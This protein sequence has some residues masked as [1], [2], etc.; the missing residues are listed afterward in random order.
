[1]SASFGAVPL[2]ERTPRLLFDEQL[3]PQ[4]VRQLA[5][6]FPDSA[7]VYDL[8]LGG[9]RDSAV[10]DAALQNGFVLITKDEDFQS[11][12]V[13]RGHPP[14]VIWVRIGNASVA[15]TVEFFRVRHELIAAFAADPEAGFL[16]LS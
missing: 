13:F 11:V 15:A 5:S 7:H 10:W 16:A 4:L 1:V 2:P 12:S 3:P 14:K 8:R 6:L 9:A